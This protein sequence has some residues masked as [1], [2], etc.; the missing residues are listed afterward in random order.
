MFW[1]Q[2]EKNV[3]NTLMFS[4]VAKWCL[5]Q[6]KD[7]SASHA[8]PARKL[9]G[10][11]KLAQDTARAADITGQKDIPYHGMSCLVYKLVVVGLEDCCSGTNWESV[12]E[13]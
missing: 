11:Q 12:G 10:H 7:F 8:Q 6:V 4:V 5:D 2:Y 13:W 9:E 1:V 3:D